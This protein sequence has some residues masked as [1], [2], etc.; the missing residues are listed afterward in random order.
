MAVHDQLNAL[1]ANRFVRLESS[2]AGIKA[3]DQETAQTVLLVD[4]PTLDARLVGVFHPA[5]VSV[6]AIVDHQGRRLAASEFVQGRSLKELFHGEP[7]HPRRAAEIVSEIADGVAELHARGII[8]GNITQASAILTT[9]GKARLRLTSAIGGDDEVLDVNELK[10]LLK[11]IGGQP[12]DA[13]NHS[14][15]AAVLAASLR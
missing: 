14:Q 8:H 11:T 3:R 2:A 15:S 12:N 1:I 10:V 7:C 6:F 4:A 13:A 5:L 9:K